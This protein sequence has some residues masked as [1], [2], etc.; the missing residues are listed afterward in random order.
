MSDNTDDL[1]HTPVGWVRQGRELT[2]EFRFK[3]FY[4]TMS[5]VNAV[6]HLANAADHH[7]DLAVSYNKCG[8]KLTTHDAGGITAKDVI[9]AESISRLPE[10]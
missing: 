7:P 5:F 6:A 10:L 8:I 2:R 3:N 9:L 1:L 4:A